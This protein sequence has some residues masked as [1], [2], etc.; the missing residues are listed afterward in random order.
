[1]S[2]TTKTKLTE[3]QLQ[4][5]EFIKQYHRDNLRSPTFREIG[6]HFGMSPNGVTCHLAALVKKKAII[7]L[8]RSRGLIVREQVDADVVQ[9]IWG[10]FRMGA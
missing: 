7:K 6:G 4:V 9:T 1:M 5:L 8:E 3:R 10:P 2:A